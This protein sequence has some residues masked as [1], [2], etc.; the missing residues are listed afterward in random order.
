M[1]K[2][3]QIK[4]NFNYN[5]PLDLSQ[6]KNI[7]QI[8]TITMDMEVRF[9]MK[10][11]DLGSVGVDDYKWVFGIDGWFW[12]YL[13]KSAEESKYYINHMQWNGLG[14]HDE[15]LKSNPMS[16]SNN[17]KK[18]FLENFLKTQSLKQI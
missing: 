6:R 18:E 16:F 13:R 2:N 14:E 9:E 15:I 7:G 1:K 4:E 11:Q 17:W 12:F 10:I 5:G 8:K 3:A